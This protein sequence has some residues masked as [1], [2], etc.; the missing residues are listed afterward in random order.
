MT[1]IIKKHIRKTSLM[2]ASALM[3]T[4]TPMTSCSDDT[5]SN[6]NTDETKVSELDTNAQLTTDLLQT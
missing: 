6:I 1:N 3:A 5:S 4:G 2:M